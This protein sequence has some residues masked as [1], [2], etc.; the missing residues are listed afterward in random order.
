M[1]GNGPARS[2]RQ[3]AAGVRWFRQVRVVRPRQPGRWQKRKFPALR[4]G[5][6]GVGHECRRSQIGRLTITSA[7]WATGARRNRAYSLQSGGS[8]GGDSPLAE[9]NGDLK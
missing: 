5:G 6:A 4:R 9:G 8:R 3:V 1:G 2:A 7:L